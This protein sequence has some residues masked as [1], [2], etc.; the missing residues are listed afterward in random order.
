MRK[1]ANA[2]LLRL[3][4]AQTVFDVIRRERPISRAEVARLTGMAK[5]TVSNVL[6][7]LLQA[8]LVRES[9]DGV[10]RQR[11]NTF[12][13][14]PEAAYVLGVDVGAR[15]LRAA[16][17][18]LSGT[19]HARG[20]V[21]HGGDTAQLPDLAL[22][23]RNRLLEEAG[24][25]LPALEA[26]V[27][28]VPGIINPEDG[29][30][31]RLNP[32]RT[33]TYPIVAAM[34]RSLGHPAVVENDINLAAIG[35]QWRGLAAGVDDFVFLSIGTGVGMGLVL[36]GRL[37]RGH[38]GAAGEVDLP[39]DAASAAEHAM[40]TY[41]A[42]HHGLRDT[43]P[44]EIFARAAAGDPAAIAVRSEQARRIAAYIR[45]IA[46]ITDVELVVLG[47]GIGIHCQELLEEVRTELER[48]VHY[49]PRLEISALGDTPV[50]VGALALG[51]QDC[52]SRLVASRLRGENEE[53][54]AADQLG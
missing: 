37:H 48:C 22:G 34:E 39:G 5:P 52:A 28:G 2:P 11:G 36:R 21:P 42:E 35:E 32:E 29:K 24:V 17:A 4:N 45:P 38:R 20:A 15:F 54:P 19:V 13:P 51:I 40:L 41:A 25:V 44:E 12:E 7:D 33:E 43:S 53:A 1:S 49:P 14:V 31:W 47:G 16:L 18:D 30:I 9:A 8:G 6:S 10:A 3:L 26:T 27:I 46:R 50:L 23:L